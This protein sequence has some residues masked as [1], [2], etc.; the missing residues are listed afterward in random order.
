MQNQTFILTD[1]P[2]MSNKYSIG[3]T[4]KGSIIYKDLLSYS[5]LKLGSRVAEHWAAKTVPC[6]QYQHILS[7]FYVIYFV[8][9]F[10]LHKWNI[11]LECFCIR[12]RNI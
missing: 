3:Y 9:I 6:E 5:I 11:I 1:D 10:V 8:V 12:H 4:C 7:E 2:K